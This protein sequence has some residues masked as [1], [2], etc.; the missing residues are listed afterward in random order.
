MSTYQLYF[1]PGSASLVVHWVLLELAL[2]HELIRLDLN[3][4]EHKRPEYLKLN[5]AGL[6]PTLVQDGVAITEAAA[7]VMHLA[8]QPSTLALAPPLASIERAFYYQ[9]FGLYQ[10][11]YQ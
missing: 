10:V 4:G 11:L 8:D 6:V 3:A 1:S 7:I 5:P 2:E 9:W